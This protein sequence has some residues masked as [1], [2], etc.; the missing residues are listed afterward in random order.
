MCIFLGFS[1]C[2]EEKEGLG[3]TFKEVKEN[4]E[5]GVVSYR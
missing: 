5:L 1:L 2:L 3:A 4:D